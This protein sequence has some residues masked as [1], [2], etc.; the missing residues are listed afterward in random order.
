MHPAYAREYLEEV[1]RID[2]DYAQFR[3]IY[4]NAEAHR[5]YTELDEWFFHYDRGHDWQ[6]EEYAR[7][8]N[9]IR[10]RYA[11]RG[12]T[13]DELFNLIFGNG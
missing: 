11:E 3:P 13:G 12:P 2:N 7:K 9:R 8:L 1:S 5:A 10:R 6:L 4:E